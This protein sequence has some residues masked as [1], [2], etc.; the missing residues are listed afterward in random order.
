MPK[1][2]QPSRPPLK[3][4]SALPLI[5][6]LMAPRKGLLVLGLGLMAI[7]RVAGLV[8]PASTKWLIDDV[9]G[10]RHVQ[11][12]VPL[13]GV[14]VLATMVQGITS[15]ALTQSLSKAAQRLIAELRRKVQAHVSRLPVAFYDANK[16]GNLVSRIMQDVEGVRNLIGTGLVDF[17]GGMF[18]AAIAL[19][20]LLRISPRM[21]LLAIVFL[22]V[23]ALALQRAFKTIRPIFRERSKI[24][25]EISGRLT[26]SIGG[27][28]VVK[29][30]HA[31]ER[32]QGVFASGVERLLANV[33]RTLTATSLMSLSSSVLLGA[34]GAIIMYMGTRQILAGTLTIGGFF[35]YTLFLGF[36]IAP[37]AQTVAVGTQI[38]EAI[39]GLERTRE[40]LTENPE[41]ED[42]RRKVPIDDMIGN[43]RF[44][45]VS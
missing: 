25:A 15:F 32:E 14:V 45:H 13:V 4:R 36:L 31:E 21:T 23:F 16:S 40:I 17:I 7:N 30:Y 35:T 10:K 9:I 1:P 20:V 19:I 24:N 2:A 29:G 8:L 6:E 39:A 18:T 11:L 3:L 43:V 34:V 44:E 27:V 42:P 26:E 28:R 33:L 38:T 22:M 5:W 12:L 41:D 37:V